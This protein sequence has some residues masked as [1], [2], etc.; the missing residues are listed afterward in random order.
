MSLKEAFAAKYHPCRN[1]IEQLNT[2]KQSG[3][4]VMQQ[5]VNQITCSLLESFSRVYT[6]DGIIC[7]KTGVL[8]FRRSKINHEPHEFILGSGTVANRTNTACE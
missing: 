1:V 2:P 8:F 7:L 5:P 4:I 6:C 3:Y